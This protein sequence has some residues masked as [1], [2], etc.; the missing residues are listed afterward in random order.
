MR[1]KH[2]LTL[3]SLSLALACHDGKSGLDTLS[4]LA[5]GDGNSSGT[6]RV[7]VVAAGA[8]SSV[9]RIPGAR[10]ILLNVGTVPPDTIPDS[11]PGPPQPPP[12]PVES[13]M[14]GIF[15]D[16]VIPPPDSTPPPPPP[17]DSTP[18]DSTPPPPPPPGCG[19]TGEAVAR[20]VTNAEGAVI[21]T[22]L[23]SAKYDILVEVPGSD[24]QG[25]FCGVHLLSGQTA[26]IQ[27]FVH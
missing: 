18:P 27:I 7:R 17:P 23:P 2:L 15:G 8:D 13:L 12:P 24:R 4:N 20:A 14:A 5:D 19:R 16:T 22:G 21:F 26:T 1:L 6:V 10:V 11:I 3:S 9:T 25:A